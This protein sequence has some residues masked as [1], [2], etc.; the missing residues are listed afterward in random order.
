MRLDVLI[1][2]DLNAYAM[3]DPNAALIGVGAWRFTHGGSWPWA[4]GVAGGS[5]ALIG[6]TFAEALGGAIAMTIAG[7]VLIVTSVLLLRTH[8]RGG[9][10]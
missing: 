9:Q 6:L 7:V 5:A 8:R 4:V 2:D 1:I 3:E 10:G